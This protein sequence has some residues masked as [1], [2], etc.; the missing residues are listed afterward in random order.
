MKAPGYLGGGMPS[1]PSVLWCQAVFHCATLYR[2]VNT[3]TSNLD[4][5]TINY[6]KKYQMF[7]VFG[8]FF[9]LDYHAWLS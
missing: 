1:F 7:K 5:K 3:A 6:K 8:Y 9:A 2:F 4:N